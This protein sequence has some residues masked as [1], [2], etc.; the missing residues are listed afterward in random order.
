MKGAAPAGPA[1]AL[2]V[3]RPGQ[4]K[5]ELF[6]RKHHLAVYILLYGLA[7]KSFALN[8]ALERILSSFEYIFN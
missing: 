2:L 3:D 7:V 8:P 1:T 5:V 6:N 4:K